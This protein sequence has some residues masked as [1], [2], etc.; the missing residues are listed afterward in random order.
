MINLLD[1]VDRI[2][3]V[4]T[5]KIEA[6]PPLTHPILGTK[7]SWKMFSQKLINVREGFKK[8]N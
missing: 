2:R 6:P 7:K 8:I 3:W 4:F 5:N 1:L